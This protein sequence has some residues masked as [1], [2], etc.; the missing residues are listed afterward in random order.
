V[1]LRYEQ[2]NVIVVHVVCAVSSAPLG[3]RH[4][5]PRCRVSPV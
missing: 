2:E 1:L 3:E 4:T 5:E